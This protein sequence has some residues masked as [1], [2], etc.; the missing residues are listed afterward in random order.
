MTMDRFSLWYSAEL[1]QMMM[2]REIVRAFK[3][4]VMTRLTINSRYLPGETTKNH[5]ESQKY[6]REKK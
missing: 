2:C 1:N 3:A 4:A 5:K 6:G